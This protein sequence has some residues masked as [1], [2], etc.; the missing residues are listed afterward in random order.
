MPKYSTFKYGKYRYGKYNI[1]IDGHVELDKIRNYRIRT[2]N[3]NAEESKA[4]ISQVITFKGAH[5]KAPIRMKANNSDKYV[6]LQ[7]K[8][9]NGAPI[10]I[11]IRS[12]SKNNNL[13][14]WVESVAGIISATK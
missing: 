12:V 5:N 11:R 9:I 2:M 14:P 13:S 10:K 7:S 8:T 3:N 4:V 6:Y 1:Q